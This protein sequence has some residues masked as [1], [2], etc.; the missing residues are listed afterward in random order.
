M[1]ADIDKLQR[2]FYHKIGAGNAQAEDWLQGNNPIGRP[3]AVIF[4]GSITL[5][6]IRNRRFQE[7]SNSTISQIED[8]VNMEGQ[9]DICIVVV[10]KKVWFL[11]PTG[12]I[13]ERRPESYEDYSQDS[14][15]KIMPVDVIETKALNEVPPILA[16]ISANQY[17]VRGT[18]RPI[19]E[20][21][22]RGNLKAIYSVLG[23][24]WDS[25]WYENTSPSGLFECLSSVEL[26]TL[27]AKILE[28][29][30]CF[31][32]AYR[33]GVLKYVDLFAYSERP[34]NIDGLNVNSSGVMIQVK[35]N[36]RVRKAK[37][38]EGTVLVGYNCKTDGRYLN[39]DWLLGQIR[40]LPDVKQWIIRSL[41]WIPKD[42]LSIFL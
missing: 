34:I 30:D 6:D 13:Q 33:G 7:R 1:S 32:P 14:I 28:S 29:N 10:D 38:P 5:D 20:V 12:T 40:T 11:T 8:F 41:N 21:S 35:A 17:L 27:V 15:R 9:D 19:S 4:Y 18:F 23:K 37:L 36:T 16:S 42:F 25:K 26:E 39:E 22:Y 24:A 3:A 31:V 2:F